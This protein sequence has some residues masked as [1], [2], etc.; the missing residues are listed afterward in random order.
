MGM[1]ISTSVAYAAIKE[2][3]VYVNGQKIDFQSTPILEQGRV[4]APIRDLAESLGSVVSWDSKT[5]SVLIST[6]GIPGKTAPSYSPES[7]N[8]SGKVIP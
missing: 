8:D 1:I 3:S 7:G 5:N 6:P 4:I 2:I